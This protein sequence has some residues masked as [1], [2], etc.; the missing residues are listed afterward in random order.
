MFQTIEEWFRSIIGK[1]LNAIYG[2]IYI[3]L[4][5]DINHPQELQIIFENEITRKISCGSDGSTLR[6]DNSPMIESDLGEYGKQLIMDISNVPVFQQAVGEKLEKL[7]VIESKRE[8]CIVGINLKF[9]NS[10]IINILTIGDEI[11]YYTS[12]PLSIVEDEELIFL[13]ITITDID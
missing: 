6:I 12:I 2:L 13:P 10:I 11:S 1:K 9:S 4:T 7:E 5:E 8:Q 3:Y